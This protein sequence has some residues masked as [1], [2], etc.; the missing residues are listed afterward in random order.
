MQHHGGTARPSR[1]IAPGRRLALLLC[2]VGALGTS[3]AACGK[4]N[5]Y[6]PPPPP[7][8]GVSQ[9]V[10]RKVVPF[11]ESTGSAVAYNA[12]DLQARVQGFV[13]AINFQ[14][15]E[16]VSAGQSLFVIEPA[17][18][19]A[20][21]QQAQAALASAQAQFVQ[22]DAEY[23]RQAALG[24]RDF[25]S[26]STIDQARATRDSNKANVSNQEAVLT[27]A[28][29]TLGYTQV[30][31][32]FAGIV[33]AHL[34][35]LGDLVGVTGPTKLASVVQLDPIYVTF[36]LSEQDVQQIRTMMRKAGVAPGNLGQIKVEVGL[37]AEDGYPHS[38]VLDYAAPEVDP[39]TGTLLVRAVLQNPDRTLLPGYFVRLRIPAEPLAYQAL[40]VPDAALGTNQ[41]GR[42]LLVVNSDNV[43]EQRTV[44]TG[45][46]DGG[47]RVVSGQLKPDDK[48]VISGISHA[49]PGEKVVAKPVP[50][51]GT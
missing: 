21:F 12:V 34:V 44:V 42:Y 36:N 50:M 8:V 37:M 30:K 10:A 29:I 17:P 7:E 16:Q 48:V 47:L 35:S 6:A 22:S 24:T 51:P 39:S 46:L 32:P 15:G 3:L 19:A 28:G 13:Q 25:S 14:D 4:K 27:Q 1:G 38:G 49:I 45:Q 26:R 5:A 40:L 20:K 23:N 18:Y 31:A 43:V 2:L 11:M 41:A 33:T 9:P